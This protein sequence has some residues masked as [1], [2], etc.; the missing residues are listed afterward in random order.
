VVALTLVVSGIVLAIIFAVGSRY[1]LPFKRADI[2]FLQ[3]EEVR[4]AIS[5]SGM[6]IKEE[7]VIKSPAPGVLKVLVD[8]GQRVRV[9]EPVLRLQLRGGEGAPAGEV[10]VY[11]PRT[12]VLF[13]NVDGLEGTLSPAHQKELNIWP[14]VRNGAGQAAE[15]TSSVKVEGGVPVAKV[16]DNLQP[17]LFYGVSGE[18]AEDTGLEAGS[19]LELRWQDQSLTARLEE[20]REEDREAEMILSFHNYPDLLIK[21][22]WLE[23]EVTTARLRGYLVPLEALAHRESRPGILTV[24]KKRAAWTPVT[25]QEHLGGQVAIKGPGLAEHT[26]YIANPG[27]FKEGERVE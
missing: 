1:G 27:S 15:Q 20:I 23:V 10:T 7:T 17:V 19:V 21:Q 13:T 22:R 14:L 8:E 3:L 4:N 6:L 11:S 12:G 25:V 18:L 2:Q 16:V 9:G 5:V 24:Y 26:R